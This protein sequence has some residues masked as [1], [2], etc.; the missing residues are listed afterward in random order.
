M[1]EQPLD[2]ILVVTD[3]PTQLNRRRVIDFAAAHR[4]PGVCEYAFLAHGGGLMAYGPNTDG[5]FDCA[6]QIPTPAD[7]KR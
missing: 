4:L 2:V 5:I 3:I 6:A 7:S 1:A